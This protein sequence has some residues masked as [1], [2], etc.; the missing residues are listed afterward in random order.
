MAPLCQSL[1]L[2]R[3][4]QCDVFQCPSGACPFMALVSSSVVVS[5]PTPDQTSNRGLRQESLGS[6]HEWHKPD[7][8]D[9]RGCCVRGDRSRALHDVQDEEGEADQVCASRAR[10]L[11][12]R[13]W[14][15]HTHNLPPTQ[16]EIRHAPTHAHTRTPAPL[17]M[18][19]PSCGRYRLK[20]THHC[21][22]C[23]PLQGCSRHAHHR[24]QTQSPGY[25]PHT[26]PATCHP[27]THKPPVR[28]L[29]VMLRPKSKEQKKSK[30]H[31]LRRRVKPKNR[32]SIGLSRLV[33]EYAIF[34]EINKSILNLS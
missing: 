28:W 16:N 23:M 9:G 2:S 6:N 5:P 31:R 18:H 30:Q 21:C 15:T 27:L 34:R 7:H 8:G 24:K 22:M 29:S 14:G 33:S 3:F 11:H 19:A 10:A 1:W 32:I 20:Y 25:P 4:I 17:E 12:L 13:L 26:P